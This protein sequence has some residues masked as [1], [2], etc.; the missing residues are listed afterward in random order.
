MLV[1]AAR[2]AENGRTFPELNV[3]KITSALV[4]AACLSAVALPQAAAQAPPTLSRE[5]I[6]EIVRDYLLK[7]PEVIIEA[8][9]GLEEKRR[10]AT[11]ES[12]SEALATK[13]AQIFN[14]PD[15]PVAGNP[16][17]DVTLVEFFDYR[18]PYCKQV[19]PD[20]SR[21][22]K[23]DGKL[24]FVFKELPVLGPDSVAA[25]RAALA[26]DM[27]GRYVE[28]HDALLRHRGSYS[29]QAIARIAAEARLD[30]A[31]LKADMQKPEITAMLDRNRQLAR[32]LAVNGTPAFIVGNVIVP[33]AVDLATLK[34]LVAE[35]RQ[36]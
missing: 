30:T 25:A 13:H 21:L 1:R 2:L 24:R 32:D 26:A 27:Q 23:E 22:I 4:V 35:A 10:R 19:A 29:D 12:Q 11:Q 18:C 17:G 34:K 9:E 14:D 15:S 31:R 6:E 8:I 3:R 16:G 36:R 28:M 7:N 20:L 33:G 5:Q